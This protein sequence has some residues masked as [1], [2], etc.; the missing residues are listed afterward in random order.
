MYRSSDRSIDDKAA[1]EIEEVKLAL[2]SGTDVPRVL[3]VD[4]SRARAVKQPCSFSLQVL[5]LSSSRHA[6]T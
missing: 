5:V 1:T 6:P 3:N 4:V 2:F